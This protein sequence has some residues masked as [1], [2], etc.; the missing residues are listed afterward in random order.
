MS[1][2][3]A[4]SE[5]C[6]TLSSEFRDIVLDDSGKP[7]LGGRGEFA[8]FNSEASVRNPH[9]LHRRVSHLLPVVTSLIN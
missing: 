9:T 3:Y 2:K 6:L 8:A 7:Y 5:Y 1:C 4:L